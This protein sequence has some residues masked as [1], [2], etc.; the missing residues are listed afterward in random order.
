MRTMTRAL[1]RLAC[2]A[3]AHPR[4]VLALAFAV[5]IAVV[6]LMILG[7]VA[8]FTQ[9]MLPKFFLFAAVT[10]AAFVAIKSVRG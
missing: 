9:P 1:G 7:W 6:G 4:A 8:L 5:T 2:V 10:L 3:N